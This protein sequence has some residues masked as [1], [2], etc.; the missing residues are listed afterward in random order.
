MPT[1]HGDGPAIGAWRTGH[2]DGNHPLPF[3]VRDYVLED[4]F[5]LLH[6]LRKPGQNS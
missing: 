6:I 4:R 1:G 2:D 3:G 5:H